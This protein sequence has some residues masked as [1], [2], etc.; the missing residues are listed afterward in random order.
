VI[1]GIDIRRVILGTI[2]GLEG[3]WIAFAFGHELLTNPIFGL[4]YRWHVA[5]A[6]RLLDLGSPYWPWQ[7]AGQY[8]VANGAILYPP[9]AF[10]LFIPFIWLPAVLWWAVPIGITVASLLSHR[11]PLWAWAV[12]G[13]LFAQEASLNVYVFGNPSMWAVAAV[14]A[15]TA[16]GW[17]FVVLIAKPT[18]LP[19]ALL[20]ARQRRSWWICFGALLIASIPFG[21]LWIEWLIAIRNSNLTALYNLPTLPL[22]I[23]PLVGWYA[24]R[25]RSR[26]SA[27]S[28]ATETSRKR[29]AVPVQVVR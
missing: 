8:G 24:S 16:L 12:M 19:L 2:V 6:Q 5:A 18:F 1:R 23:A 17:P 7:L 25:R 3:L 13:V 4:D 10:L 14:A 15:G 9:I 11:P 27:P 26:Q 22:L 28:E 29:K 21:G 20:G